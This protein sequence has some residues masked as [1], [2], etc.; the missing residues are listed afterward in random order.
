[1]GFG[2][3]IG[4]VWSVEGKLLYCGILNFFNIGL[5][6]RVGIRFFID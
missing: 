6:M 1:M 5:W 4:G 2:G 3:G